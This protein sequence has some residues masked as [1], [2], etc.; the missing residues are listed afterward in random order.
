MFYLRLPE[1]LTPVPDGS[2]AS[3]GGDG[4]DWQ[5]AAVGDLSTCETG[6]LLR[7]L[8]QVTIIEIYN[9]EY[10]FWIMVT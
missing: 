9:K 5:D 8:F 3:A 6:L 1:S 2:T 10:G 7:Q 4:W